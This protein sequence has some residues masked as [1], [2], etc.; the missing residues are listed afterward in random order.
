MSTVYSNLAK[1]TPSGRRHTLSRPYMGISIEPAFEISDYSE[2]IY[3]SVQHRCMYTTFNT[4]MI[5]VLFQ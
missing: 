2:Y 3:I 5:Q 1:A 4:H